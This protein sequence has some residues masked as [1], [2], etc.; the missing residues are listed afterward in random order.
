MQRRVLGLLIATVLVK[1]A[2][3]SVAAAKSRVDAAQC[4]KFREQGCQLVTPPCVLPEPPSC[5]E[6]RC[7]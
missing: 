3:A 1:R 4:R 6:G 7:R 5:A 2:I